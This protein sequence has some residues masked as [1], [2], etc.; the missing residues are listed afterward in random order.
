M[1]DSLLSV[2]TLDID[3]FARRMVR[4]LEYGYMSATGLSY[5]VGVQ[6]HKSLEAY[7]NGIEAT[8]SGR[9]RCANVCAW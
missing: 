9:Q 3:D 5:G 6:T 1:L 2:G 4:W 7:M 8:R